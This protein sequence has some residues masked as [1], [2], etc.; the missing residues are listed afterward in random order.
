VV[1]VPGKHS[2]D[3]LQATPAEI[4]S[5]PFPGKFELF[6]FFRAPS[7]VQEKDSTEYFTHQEENMFAGWRTSSCHASSDGAGS[8]I[9]QGLKASTY[10]ARTSRTI[11]TE[12]LS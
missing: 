1:S 12:R 3:V 11:R 9:A 4:I 6:S 8:S 5:H 7:M 2:C 10:E